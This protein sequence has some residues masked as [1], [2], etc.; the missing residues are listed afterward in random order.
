MWFDN[1]AT[2]EA[3]WRSEAGGRAAADNANC[4]DLERTR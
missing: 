4:L 2:M 1:R 3:A